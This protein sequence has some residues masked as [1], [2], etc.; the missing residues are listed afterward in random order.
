MYVCHV[1]PDVCGVGAEDRG[2]VT[3]K[4]NYFVDSNQLSI[5]PPPPRCPPF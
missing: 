1:C 5:H 4:I 2:E 3:V